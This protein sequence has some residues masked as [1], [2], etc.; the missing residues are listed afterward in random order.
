MSILTI[1]PISQQKSYDTKLHCR[2]IGNFE[3]LVGWLRINFRNIQSNK[4]GIY[5]SK[6]QIHSKFTELDVQ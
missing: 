4:F 1:T 5:R 6:I 3:I 2:I